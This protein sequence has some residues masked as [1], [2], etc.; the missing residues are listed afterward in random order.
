MDNHLLQSA[1]AHGGRRHQLRLHQRAKHAREM[2][3]ALCL[4]GARAAHHDPLHQGGPVL[5][6]EGPLH[7]LV[8]CLQVGQAALLRQS[9]EAVL[10]LAAPPVL[11]GHAELLVELDLERVQ[12][13]QGQGVVVALDHHEAVRGIQPVL[14]LLRGRVAHL[15]RRRILLLRLAAA[16]GTV[17]LLA[18]GAGI[19]PA[20]RLKDL[21]DSKGNSQHRVLVLKGPLHPLVNCLQVGQAALLRQSREA[22]LRLA[23]PPVLVGH[24]ELLVELDLERVQRAQGQGVVV[25]LDHHEAVRGIQPVLG[26]LRGRVAH[27]PRRRILLLR[28]AAAGGTVLLLAGGAGILPALRLKDLQDSKGNSQHRVL[29]LVHC[30]LL[31]QSRN[32]GCLQLNALLVLQAKE[33]VGDC[34]NHCSLEALAEPLLQALAGSLQAH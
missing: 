17:L 22:V 33:L 7:P 4:H 15:P 10:R 31:H 24:A 21:Q 18:G 1:R 3:H 12:R 20:L 5:G 9:R 2:L 19:L 28:L 16:G 8:N 6:Q 25:A 23:A 30:I 34:G 27:L 14:G 29:V 26:L 11:V 32:A 13:A